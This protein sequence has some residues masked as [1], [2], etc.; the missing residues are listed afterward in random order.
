MM[1][2]KVGEALTDVVVL[3][4]EEDPE[5]EVMIVDAAVGEGVEV[6]IIEEKVGVEVESE[7]EDIAEEVRRGPL[8]CL[9]LPYD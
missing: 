8:P 6:A 4:N 7:V 3:R 1:T 9:L 5:V 2:E